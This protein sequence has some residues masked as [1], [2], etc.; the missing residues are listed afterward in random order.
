MGEITKNENASSSPRNH[1]SSPAM[2]QNWIENEFNELTEASFRK[3]EITNYS[4]PKEPILTQCK[5]TKNIE[6]R[7]D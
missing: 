3:W 5:E 1:N 4:E 7:L 2:E 6:K